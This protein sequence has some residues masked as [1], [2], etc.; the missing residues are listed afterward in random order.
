MNFLL[1]AFM[2]PVNVILEIFGNDPDNP[3]SYLGWILI[4]GYGFFMAG[5]GTLL[6]VGI[7]ISGFHMLGMIL[8][9]WI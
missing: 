8:F 9:E 1:A 4:T 5:I 7:I 6:I 3:W 2:F